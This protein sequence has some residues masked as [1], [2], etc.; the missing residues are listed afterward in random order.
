[1][2]GFEQH[3]PYHMF[4]VLEHT[5]YVVQRVPAYPLARWAALFHDSGKPAAFFLDGE[6][7]H[8]YGH[9]KQ[10]MWLARGALSRLCLSQSFVDDV[11]K[12]VELHDVVIQ[13][14]ARSVKKAL[15]KLDGRVDLFR[16]LCEL[17]RADAMAQTELAIP[18]IELAEQLQATLETL[19]DSKEAFTLAQLAINGNDII[20]LGVEPGRRIGA[21]LDSVLDAVIEESV[22]NERETLLEFVREL[23]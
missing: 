5:A 2:K 14:T 15:A 7:G 21:L 12:L 19:L 11:V 20:A 6:R 4:D 16:A 1:M 17:K 10:S 18:R 13:P 9:A 8:F 23:I 3:T 22:A